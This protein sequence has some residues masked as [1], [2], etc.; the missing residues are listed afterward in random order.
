[1]K[2]AYLY[3]ELVKVARER[4]SFNFA[5]PSSEESKNENDLK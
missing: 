1:M 3:E 5:S 4:Y 2:P